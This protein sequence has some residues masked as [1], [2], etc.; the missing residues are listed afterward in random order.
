MLWASKASGLGVLLF[1]LLCAPLTAASLPKDLKSKPKPSPKGTFQGLGVSLGRGLR[2]TAQVTF[3][4]LKAQKG[5]RIFIAP[6]TVPEQEKAL[7]MS[8]GVLTTSGGLLSHAASFARERGIA[9]VILGRAVWKEGEHPVLTFE[10]PVFGPVKKAAGGFQYRPVQRF[11]VRRIREDE[12]ITLD[13]V[14]GT[15][16]VY[17][18]AQGRARLAVANAVRAY[19]GLKDG[20]ALVQ[21][22]EADPKPSHGAP[23]LEELAERVFDGGAR[24]EDLALVRKAVR[25]RVP[26][27]DRASLSVF[28]KRL[29]EGL[30]TRFIRRLEDARSE[31]QDAGSGLAI[32]RI[33]DEQIDHHDGLK[34]L[35]G[36]FSTKDRLKDPRKGFLSFMRLVRKR[37]AAVPK[38]RPGEWMVPAR[39]AGAATAAQAEVSGSLYDRFIQ[40]SGL[41][42]KIA[43]IADD[44]SLRLKGKSDRI[45]AAIIRAPLPSQKGIGKEILAV[46]DAALGDR[47]SEGP[48]L[49]SVSGGLDN[50]DGVTRSEIPSKVKAAWASLWERGPLGQRKRAGYT[51][52]EPTE[53]AVYVSLMEPA[54]SSGVVFT[55]DP[56]SGLRGRIHV[57]G[58]LGDLKGLLSGSSSADRYVLDRARGVEIVP[59]VVAERE[60]ERKR[61]FEV[62]HLKSIARIARALD[63]HGGM[64]LEV[65]FSYRG[66]DLYVLRVRPLSVPAAA[67]LPLAALKP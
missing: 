19:D 29:F 8:E 58:A 48:S 36:F 66:E 31:V 23:L 32:S 30:R 7:R 53:T 51:L 59:A 17:P 4:P 38:G 2:V 43:S 49:F 11:I 1:S 25:A 21:W 5:G 62:E 28:E 39:A 52:P 35:A 20:Q 60:G 47:P 42:P 46:V 55:R 24:P 22:F 63:S 18:E 57:H 45:T 67:P 65:S 15:V 61:V 33:V 3:D 9:A 13:P 41:G 27:K 54:A 37:R 56:G 26:K 50:F 64:G 16:R 6:F 44:A 14:R 34:A 12:P 10:E 40:E